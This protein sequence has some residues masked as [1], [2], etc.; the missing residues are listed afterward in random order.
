MHTAPP[1]SRK[2]RTAMREPLLKDLEPLKAI[3]DEAKGGPVGARLAAVLKDIL[4]AAY[5]DAVVVSDTALGRPGVYAR[6]DGTLSVQFKELRRETR[7]YTGR[8]IDIDDLGETITNP[9][10]DFD[11]GQIRW[12]AVSAILNMITMNINEIPDL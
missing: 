1:T 12:D 11:A 8:R 6:R 5:N 4:P 3:R 7:T 9:T 2:I 10:P